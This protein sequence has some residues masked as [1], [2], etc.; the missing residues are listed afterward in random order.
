MFDGSVNAR[1]IERIQA[2][3]VVAASAVLNA[4]SPSHA[5]YSLKTGAGYECRA[6]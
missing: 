3:Y 1:T 2:K 5:I 6:A 4:T